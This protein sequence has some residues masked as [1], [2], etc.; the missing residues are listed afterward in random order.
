VVT[1]SADGQIVEVRG[2]QA[3]ELTRGYTCP[4]GRALGRLHHDPAR[5][6]RPWMGDPGSQRPSDWSECLDDLA[7]RLRRIIDEHGPDAVA[8][9]T[10]TFSNLDSAASITAG[11]FQA[12]IG[13]R[14]RYTSAT[15]DAISKIMVQGLVS[16]HPLLFPFADTA[17]TRMLVLV[18]TNPVVSHGATNGWPDPVNLLRGVAD[19]G[20]LWVLDPRRTESA[21]LATR[22]LQPRVGTDDAVLAYLVREVLAD[23]A[24]KEYIARHV[25]GIETI[26]AAVEPFDVALASS[27]SGVATSDLEDMLAAVRRAG[28]VTV[29]TG[30]GP[31]MAAAR[32]STELLVW[33]LGA[34]TGSL[35]REGG[36]WFHPG[37]FN[38]YDRNPVPAAI[39]FPIG[40]GPASRPDLAAPFGQFPCAALA[41]EID[42]GN[43]RAVVVVGGNPLRSFPDPER[44]RRSFERLDVLASLDILWSDTVRSSTHV[45]SCTDQLEQPEI[46]VY[47]TLYPMI[48][49]QHSSAVVA[50]LAE[51]RPVWWILAQLGRRLGFEVL[52]NGLD[53]DVCTHEEVLAAYVPPDRLAM[54]TEAESVVVEAGPVYGWV[55]ERLL[56]DGRWQFNQPQILDSIR[57]TPPSASLVLCPRRQVRQMNSMIY[58]TDR[59]DG[60]DVLVHPD[61]AKTAGIVDGGLVRV[62][63]ANG[64]VEGR[65]RVTDD[66][67]RGAVSVPHG[68]SDPNVCSLTSDADGV[69]P[70]TGM[71]EQS[72]IAVSLTP[73]AT[74]PGGAPS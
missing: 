57:T 12:G 61:D 74:P 14:S 52:P 62:A 4:K 42:A 27:I 2:D 26:R 36:T 43:V 64:F 17:R 33:A 30:T 19:R 71:V 8:L 68:F 10:A 11:G 24:D 37:F 48:A 49:A 1:T 29:I 15:I 6:D 28:R 73:I 40:A 55:T 32:D 72:G 67:A 54:L 41:D 58:P 46:L 22:H 20:E 31:Q 59:D 9:Y 16:G 38:R 3:H 50:P 65:V 35:D 60:T 66:I 51:R 53:P 69:D 13:T 44:L 5:L 7:A 56:P 25:D 34:V 45:L 18:G 47:D 39:G 21:R 23:G 63:S 70:T